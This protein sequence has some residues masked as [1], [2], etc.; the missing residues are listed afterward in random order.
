MKKNA[1]ISIMKSL[2]KNFICIFFLSEFF[3]FSLFSY[4]ETE[5]EIPVITAK[6]SQENQ[7]RILNK[8]DNI[9]I[10]I[11]TMF[12]SEFSQEGDTVEAKILVN[13][14]VQNP[15]LQALKGSKLIGEIT[16]IKRARKAG[17]SGFVKV[18][19]HTI[20]TPANKEFPIE[21]EMISEDFKGQ[22][23]IKTVWKDLK[24][25][26]KGA[27]WG[28]WTALKW[29]PAMAF[30][31]NGMSLAIGASVGISLGA[32]GA[33]RRQGDV[34][35]YLQGETNKIELKNSLNLPEE[36]I[37]EANL[38]N[39]KLHTTLM[40]VKIEL[41]DAN[42]LESNEYK[43]LLSLKLKI[44]NNSSSMIYPCDLMLIPK[45]GDDP[46]VTD[47]R[48]SKEDALKLIRSGD[49]KIITLAYPTKDKD[50]YLDDFNLALIN[51]IDKSYLA[52][53]A[54]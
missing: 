1:H 32:I 12:S 9:S 31:T 50:I 39:K 45:D 11:M 27:I 3:I 6:V 20:K 5:N 4:A 41:L 34:K 33:T 15:N 36:A 14:Y 40:G 17:K 23:A 54:L 53:I 51:P 21:A 25:V 49:E 42:L 2:K 47:L 28:G 10:S 46:L 37:I 24:L 13:Q 30:S 16:E 7:E 52:E 19:F 48:H 18:R 26:S 35:T 22:E 43:S 8:E 29:G 38:K 44:I